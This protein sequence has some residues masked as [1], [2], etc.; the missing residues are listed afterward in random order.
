MCAFKVL[1]F[2]NFHFTDEDGQYSGGT[3]E[4]LEEAL[5]KCRRVLEADL[6]HLYQE[7]MTAEDLFD[8]WMSFGDSACVLGADFK[9]SDHVKMV[10]A[11]LFESRRYAAKH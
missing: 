3:F 9:P 10:A 8:A 1:I 4:T 6:A 2:D 11:E 7:G 5:A